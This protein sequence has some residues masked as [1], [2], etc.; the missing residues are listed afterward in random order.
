MIA[1][2]DSLSGASPTGGYPSADV[3]TSASG[4]TNTSSSFPQAAYSDFRTSASLAYRRK[5]GAHLPSIDVSYSHENDY[6]ARSIGISDS[7]TMA[8]GRG[9]LHLRRLDLARRRLAR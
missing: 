5:F 7:W 8:G 1:G 6:E 3:T 9:T 2:F 4:S